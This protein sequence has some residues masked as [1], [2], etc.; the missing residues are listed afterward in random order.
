[1]HCQ[2]CGLKNGEDEHRCLHCGRRI[3]GIAISAPTSYIGATAL[4]LSV[5]PAAE[6]EREALR[7]EDR[8][9][10]PLFHSAPQP[11][12]QATAKWN[13]PASQKVIAFEDIQR[14]A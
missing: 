5:M 13:Y 12:T 3:P 10:S 6:S 2:Y 1:M 11:A 4:A 8:G 9:Q 7:E 14:E